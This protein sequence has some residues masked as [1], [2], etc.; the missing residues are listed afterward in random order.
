MYHLKPPIRI[1]EKIFNSIITPILLYGSEVWGPV[2]Y[3]DST[4]WDTSPTE[5][6]HLEF[7]KHLLQVHRSTSNNACRAELGRFPLL[8]T[9]QKRALT[10]WAHLNTSHPQSYCYRAMRSQDLLTKPCAIK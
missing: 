10:F 4:K 2:T 1:W 8:L 9:V 6:L 3:P 5:I 7:C